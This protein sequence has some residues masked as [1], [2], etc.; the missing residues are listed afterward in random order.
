[1]AN[2]LQPLGCREI[3]MRDKKME[4]KTLTLRNSPAPMLGWLI[5]PLAIMLA[6]AAIK[7]AGI[8]FDL[9]LN[10]VTPLLIVAV[11]AILGIT[12][13]VLKEN[14]AVNFS[15]SALSLAT[16]GVVMIGH[17]AIVN[18]T[19]LGAFTALQFLV[20]AFGVYFFDSRGRH[21]IATILT[22]G[23]VGV[24]LGMIAVGHYN[25]ILDDNYAIDGNVL[26]Q[27]LDYQRQ[28]LGYIFFS[29]LTIFLVLGLLVAVL[30]RGS[31]NPA[32]EEGW[33][34]KIA[35][36]DGN[37]NIAT[38]P[39]QIASVVWILAHVGSL[40]HLNQFP[41]LINLASSMLTDITATLVSGERSLPVLWP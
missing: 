15:S 23:M 18:L 27:A 30:T 26:P 4:E 5:A 22:F 29:Y 6:L 41:W 35:S 31:L 1:M 16:L 9:E 11:G 39:L 33:F 28:A 38:L 10:N 21:E 7:V 17:Q 14:G 36:Y 2:L 25:D 34:G 19:D 20:V 37:Y 3:P 13:R 40:Y 24:N 32:S 12:P 8:D